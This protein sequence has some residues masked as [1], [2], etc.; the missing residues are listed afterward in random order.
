MQLWVCFC[1]KASPQEPSPVGQQEAS[2]GQELGD[3]CPSSSSGAGG[4]SG[5]SLEAP[6]STEAECSSTAGEETPC[7]RGGARGH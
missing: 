1:W 5:H 2:P 6:W 3:R 4:E 7:G